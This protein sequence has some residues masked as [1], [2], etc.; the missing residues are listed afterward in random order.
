[1]LKLSGSKDG[2]VSRPSR[3]QGICVSARTRGS[4]GSGLRESA[5]LSESKPVYS[6]RGQGLHDNQPDWLAVLAQL[7]WLEGVS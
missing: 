5:W 6:L 4:Q 3:T 2:A 7:T 1:M